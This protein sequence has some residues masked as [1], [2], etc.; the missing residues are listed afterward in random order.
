MSAIW[1]VVTTID[2]PEAAERIAR[3]LVDQRL[4]A[5]VQIEGPCLSIYRWKG[6]LESTR[7]WRCAIKTS[8]SLFPT[9]CQ[10]I[11][12]QHSYEVPEI[13]AM[14]IVGVSDDY[15]DWLLAQLDPTRAK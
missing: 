8:E 6:E 12:Q 14:P 9:V 3:T 7:E 15:L 11:Q 5:C 1:Q 4:A 10:V 13:M 2:S